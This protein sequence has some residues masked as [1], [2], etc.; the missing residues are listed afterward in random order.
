MDISEPDRVDHD[1]IREIRK[2]W[3]VSRE[4]FGTFVGVTEKTIR[5]YETDEHI[6]SKKKNRSIEFLGEFAEEHNDLESAK[7]LLRYVHRREMADLLNPPVEW[8][9]DIEG[10]FNEAINS[11]KKEES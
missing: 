11:L 8:L 9:M 5:D 3:G 10:E 4:E 6:P 7:E 1:K 2:T